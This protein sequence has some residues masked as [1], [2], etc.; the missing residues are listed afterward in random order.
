MI[1][2][3]GGT[4]LLGLH[5]LDELSDRKIPVTAL[6][7]DPAS[8]P[9]VQTRGAVPV[10]GS[11]D[12]PETWQRV[13]DCEGII[14]AAAIVAGR[15]PW[16]YFVRVNVESTRMAATR[17]RELS[18]PLI[19]I[20]SVAVYGRKMRVDSVVDERFAFGPLAER[21]FYARTKRMAEEVL[22]EEAGRGLRATA[23]RPCVIYGEGD[24]LFF[25][26]IVRAMERGLVPLLDGGARP[27]SLVHSRNVAEAV[28]LALGNPVAA[29]KAYNVANDH[30]ITAR[31]FVAAVARGRGRRIRTIS[32]PGSAVIAAARTLDRVSRLLRPSKYPGSLATAARFWRGGNPYSSELA[33]R[34]LGWNPSVRHEDGI[35][36]AARALE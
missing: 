25:P 14:H 30:E 11:I 23:I 24:R 34:E 35:E 17:A 13:R 7:R 1:F 27:L 20:S 16:D 10:V 6:I 12:D 22:W 36:R 8:A 9:A 33:R 4:G 5:L 18:I 28:V 2:L 21:E 31:G 3:T 19:H 32:L 26:K 29:G 15:K